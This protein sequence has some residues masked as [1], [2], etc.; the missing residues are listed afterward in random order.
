MRFPTGGT[1]YEELII[2]PL[3]VLDPHAVIRVTVAMR[4]DS[5]NRDPHF[6]LTDGVNEN[7]FRVSDSNGQCQMQAGSYIT[8]NPPYDS[9]QHY[10]YVFVFEPFHKYGACSYLGGHINP[11]YFNYRI[12]PNKGLSFVVKRENTNEDYEFYYFL[13]EVL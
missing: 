6:G 11:G 10:E 2:V 3:G 13:I 12:D 1:S 5:T 8:A 4:P 7:R 9:E